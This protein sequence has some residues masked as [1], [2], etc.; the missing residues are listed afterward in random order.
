ML[1]IDMEM[2]KSCGF[3]RFVGSC[4]AHSFD[5]FPDI[6]SIIFNDVIGVDGERD[7]NCPLKPF[8]PPE[9]QI[10]TNIYDQEEIHHNCTVQVL[11]NSLTGEVSVGWLEEKE[12]GRWKD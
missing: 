1:L 11:T 9:P 10:T 6:E 8:T 4:G 2:P 5:E 12:D 7:K 3:C